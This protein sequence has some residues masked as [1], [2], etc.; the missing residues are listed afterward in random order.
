MKISL[1][2]SVIKRMN[3]EIASISDCM[4]ATSPL[5]DSDG[6]DNPNQRNNHQ[7]RKN[8]LAQNGNLEEEKSEHQK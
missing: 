2:Y 3:K 8:R 6:E 1:Y 7:S 5:S 4:Y